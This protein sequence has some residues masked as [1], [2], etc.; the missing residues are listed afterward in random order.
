MRKHDRAIPREG[1][2]ARLWSC[3]NFVITWGVT[4]GVKKN[5]RLPRVELV[6][7]APRF[8]FLEPKFILVG[9]VLLIRGE[10]GRLR[11]EQ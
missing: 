8:S 1:A 2:L 3:I 4:W 11:R 5:P 7:M 6:T 10:D 9:D